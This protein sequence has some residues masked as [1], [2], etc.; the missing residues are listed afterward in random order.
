MRRGS[1]NASFLLIVFSCNG[2]VGKSTDSAYKRVATLLAPILE[3]PYSH[4]ME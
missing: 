1:E 4:V 3:S 2:G